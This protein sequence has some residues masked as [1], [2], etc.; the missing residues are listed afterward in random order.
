MY[1]VLP[2]FPS[3]TNIGGYPLVLPFGSEA[4]DLGDF[5]RLHHK[6]ALKMHEAN[7]VNMFHLMSDMAGAYMRDAY[8]DLRD[9]GLFDLSYMPP[10]SMD[11]SMHASIMGA[12]INDIQDDGIMNASHLFQSFQDLYAA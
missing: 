9:N 7:G 12:Y 10:G 3:Y 6:L 8:E 1:N 2:M 11:L 5:S 4:E